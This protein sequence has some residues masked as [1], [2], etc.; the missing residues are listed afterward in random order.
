MGEVGEGERGADRA[1]GA[2]G[3]G[4]GGGL[5]ALVGQFPPREGETP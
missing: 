4:V 5:V 3:M 1:V 2:A